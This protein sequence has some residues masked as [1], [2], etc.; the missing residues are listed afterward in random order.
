MKTKGVTLLSLLAI[1]LICAENGHAQV[2]VQ[3]FDT[4]SALSQFEGTPPTIGQVDIIT[5]HQYS[6]GTLPFFISGNGDQ[7]LLMN[8]SSNNQRR[9]FERSTGI[10]EESFLR[11]SFDFK[12]DSSS[13][14]GKFAGIFVGDTL[15]HFS[16]YPVNK[17]RW[18]HLNIYVTETKSFYLSNETEKGE[19]G[20]TPA[21]SGEHR[22]SIFLNNSGSDIVYVGPDDR[23]SV[24]SDGFVMVW[25]DDL[26]LLVSPAHKGSSSAINTVKF[27][28]WGNSLVAL[29]QLDN[30]LITNDINIDP[31]PVEWLSFS[32]HWQGKDVELQWR[33]A[34]EMNS[35]HFVVERSADGIHFSR[36]GSKKAAGTSQ[37]EQAYQF[38]DE[39]PERLFSPVLY[40]RLL[41]VDYDGASEY[42]PVVSIEVPPSALQHVKVHPNPFRDKLFILWRALKEEKIYF[43]LYDSR[44]GLILQEER[45][46]AATDTVVWKLDTRA[47]QQLKAGLYVLEVRSSEC[48]HQYRLLKE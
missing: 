33:T 26:P 41:Q 19:L 11:I 13:A 16:H 3:S 46:M 1:L 18:A 27:L 14:A 44:G 29:A 22:I 43:R 21:F 5:E 38:K 4:L 23:T 10:N 2:L 34:T 36:I 32:A 7:Y 37:E 39:H 24:L 42:S 25:I 20:R 28:L 30:L 15:A 17:E 8:K 35:S 31:L 6:N 45:Q 12:V 48:R 47:L 9:Y 40:Y